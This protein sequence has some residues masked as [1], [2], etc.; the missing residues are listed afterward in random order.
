[1]RN[2][3]ISAL[4]VICLTSLDYTGIGPNFFF[5][6]RKPTYFMVTGN[7]WL[8]CEKDPTGYEACRKHRIE[9]VLG[10]FNEWFNHFDEDT[11]PKAIIVFSPA[12]LPDDQAYNLIYLSIEKEGFCG[13]A[14]SKITAA[15]CYVRK[16]HTIVFNLP[17]NVTVYVVAHELGHAFKRSSNH[18][19]MPKGT[20]SIMSY[21]DIPDHVL[22]ID[23]K[24]LCK[25]HPE[26]P[27]HEDTWCKGGFWDKD[28]CPSASYEES[29][30]L[31]KID[32]IMNW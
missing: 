9:Q 19:D 14:T 15:G 3:L 20:Y 30:A 18:N 2:A 23:I 8:G 31:R 10:G 11:R 22:P 5:D 29:E 1:M 6:L 12:E 4:L 26:C 27:S 16:S 17:E 21:D 25:I 7:F 32:L 24:L 28:R 13:M